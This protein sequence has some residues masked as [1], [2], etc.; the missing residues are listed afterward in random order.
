[1]VTAAN[2]IARVYGD[3][4]HE[5][6]EYARGVAAHVAGDYV[7]AFGIFRC[8]AQRGYPPAQYRLGSMY[9][10]GEGVEEDLGAALIQYYVAADREEPRAAY[11]LGCMHCMGEGVEEDPG[12]GA[13]WFRLSA[14][15]GYAPAQFSLGTMYAS[16][17]DIPRDSREAM[18]WFLLAAVQGH[19]QALLDLQAVAAD[20]QHEQSS[21]GLR[22]GR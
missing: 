11:I 17:T 18:K 14:E 7:D 16:G 13:R 5:H 1:M 21:P 12:Q 4:H 10:K 3:P 19:Q 22:N 15:W 2:G 9:H 20:L 6:H 8:L